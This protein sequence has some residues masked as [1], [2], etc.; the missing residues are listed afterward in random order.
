MTKLELFKKI[1]SKAKVNG[2]TGPDYSF[3]TGHI[4][5]GTNIYSVVFRED[6][7]KAIW[8]SKINFSVPS[9]PRPEWGV[10]LQRLIMS[11][12]KWRYLEENTL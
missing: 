2:Y 4:I 3:E 8:G 7:A 12:D 9:Y 1:M 10:V 11:S 6:F 5:D